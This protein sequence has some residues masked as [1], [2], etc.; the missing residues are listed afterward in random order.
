MSSY[1]LNVNKTF[2]HSVDIWTEEIGEA[3]TDLSKTMTRQDKVKEVIQYT[4]SP[5][6]LQIA[7]FRV[8]HT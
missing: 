5:P 1:V 3:L 4:S 7:T 2:V 6:N 8:L